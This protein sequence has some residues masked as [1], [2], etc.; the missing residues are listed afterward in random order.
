MGRENRGWIRVKNIIR[1]TIECWAPKVKIGVENSWRIDTSVGERDF[2]KKIPTALKIE[3]GNWKF[4]EKNRDL[5]ESAKVREK[6]PSSDFPLYR[7][8]NVRPKKERNSLSLSAIEWEWRTENDRQERDL[9]IA[10]L[11]WWFN[12]QNYLFLCRVRSEILQMAKNA[13]AIE[14]R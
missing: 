14:G 12:L 8:A 5:G 9:Q 4:L 13:S 11:P 3:D 7:M 1:N 10:K 6:F 2:S